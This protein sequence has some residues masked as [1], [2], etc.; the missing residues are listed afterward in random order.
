MSLLATQL[1]R[2]PSLKA[3]DRDTVWA[4]H[5]GVYDS[6]Q[7]RKVVPAAHDS[8]GGR[9]PSVFI[10]PTKNAYGDRMLPDGKTI[11]FHP[12]TNNNVNGMLDRLAGREATLYAFLGNNTYRAGKVVVK[13]VA[14]GVY[15][16]G[17]VTP[18]LPQAALVA[19]A[20]PPRQQRRVL[21]ADMD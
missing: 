9:E 5:P 16:L 6:R 3:V 10:N 13:S 1:M 8:A 18:P 15:H 4:R 19:R 21:W 20:E 7:G 2:H 11:E 14:N 17:L 12:S